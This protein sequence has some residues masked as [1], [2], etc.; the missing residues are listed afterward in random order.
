MKKLL[1]VLIAM[2]SFTSAFSQT[3]HLPDRRGQADVE[4]GSRQ[5][6]KKPF[7]QPNARRYDDHGGQRD[8]R[9]FGRQ[10]NRRYESRNQR[11]VRDRNIYGQPDP[12]SNHGIDGKSVLLGAV[13]GL[14]LGI[15]VSKL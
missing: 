11:P 15:L 2:T 8:D 9:D 13:G 10:D 5:Q 7:D 4:Y 12:R 14:I 1:I 3:G 6:E